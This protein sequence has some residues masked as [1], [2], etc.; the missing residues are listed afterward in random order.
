MKKLFV[1]IAAVAFV[2]AFTAPS[3]AA[4]WSFYGSARMSTFW[5]DRDFGDGTNDSGADD[6]LDLAHGLQGNSRIGANVKVSDNLT[7]RF[8]YGHS[9]T[10]DVRLLYGEYDF[11]GFKL[12]VGQNYQPL[13]L[14]YSAATYGPD[15]NMLDVGGVYTGRDPAVWAKFGGFKIALL[16]PNVSAIDPIEETTTWPGGVETTVTEGVVADTDVTIPQIQVGYDFKIAGLKL[17]VAGG[18]Q[19]YQIVDVNDGDDNVNSY[20]VAVGVSYNMGPFY[21]GGD[22]WTGK[23]T[24]NL[25]QAT[26]GFAPDISAGADANG[27]LDNDSH[28]FLVVAAFSLSDMLRF[29]AG[30]GYAVGDLDEAAKKDETSAYYLQAQINLA[31]GVSIVPEIG[32]YD[33]KDDSAGNDQGT[34]TYYG[35]KWQIN[36]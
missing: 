32:Y 6:D 17:S 20:M 30:F 31:K 21:F 18:W 27:V 35:L 8:E 24:G 11:G 19:S 22:Y 3:F 9:S 4:E 33:L 23:N 13:C 29:E 16:T 28:G 34:A 25:G 10:A 1:M 5:T 36:F 26:F 7:G 14:F 15:N 12:G 2:V